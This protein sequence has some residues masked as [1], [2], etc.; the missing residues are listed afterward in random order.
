MQSVSVPGQASEY[1]LHPGGA[2][3]LSFGD[4]TDYVRI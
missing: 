2:I 1:R 4:Y 3:F